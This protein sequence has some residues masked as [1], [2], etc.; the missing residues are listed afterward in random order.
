MLLRVLRVL[1][2]YLLGWITRTPI[3]QSRSLEVDPRSIR[4]DTTPVALSITHTGPSEIRIRT[5][6]S[7]LSWE[8]KVA[9]AHPA[10]S[11]GQSYIGKIAASVSWAEKRAWM[12]H[13]LVH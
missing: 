13:I 7:V 1:F 2:R 6:R 9:R 3:H 10:P 8:S 12:I 4:F 11:K 5:C